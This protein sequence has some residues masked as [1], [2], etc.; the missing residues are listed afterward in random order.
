MKSS[1]VISIVLIAF[2]V[3]AWL[4]FFFAPKDQEQI[5]FDNH[6]KQADKYLDRGLYQKAIEEYDL[7]LSILMISCIKRTRIMRFMKLIW[8]M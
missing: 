1:R 7:A 6:I 5:E 3:I 4:A 8:V 2:T